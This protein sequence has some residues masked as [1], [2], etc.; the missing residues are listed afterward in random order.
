M[1]IVEMK[2]VSAI[3]MK[4][5]ARKVLASLQEAGVAEISQI[6]PKEQLSVQD[7]STEI[8]RLESE[9]Q[10]TRYAIGVIK[11]YDHSKKSFLTPRPEISASKLKEEDED[12]ATAI[13]ALMQS[14]KSIDENINAIRQKSA[15]L[16]S[17]KAQLEQFSELDVK[18]TDISESKYVTAFC[19]IAPKENLQQIKEISDELCE[20]TFMNSANELQPIFVLMHNSVAEEKRMALKELGVVDAVLEKADA[21]PAERIKQL[22]S[23]LAKLGE[24]RLAQEKVAEEEAKKLVTLMAHEVHL[25]YC[26]RRETALAKL[27]E[28]KKVNVIEGY[29]RADGTDKL[30]TALQNAAEAYYL[31]ITDPTE[32]D[33]TPTLVVNKSALTPFEAVDEMYDTPAYRGI[34]P[35]FIMAPFYFIFFGMMLSDAVYGAIIAIGSLIVLKLRQP[36]GMFRKVTMM[37]FIC[38]FSTIIWGILFGGYMGDLFGIDAAL[39]NP[40]ESALNMLILCIAV[41]IIHIMVALVMG[42]YM[43]ARKKDWMAMIFDKGMWFLIMLAIV[44]FALGSVAGISVLSTAAVVMVIVGALGLLFTQGRHKKGI[45]KKFVGGLASWYDIT[46]Y[47]SDILSYS[48]IFGM[49]LATSVIAMVFNTIAGMLTGG[50][51][52]MAIIGWIFAIVIFA[53]GHIFNMFIS[54]LGAFVH[55]M[56]LQYIESFTKFFEGGGRP[57][58][59]LDYSTRVFRIK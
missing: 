16:L 45:V 37:I 11:R 6:E 52:F 9:L 50:G 12:A 47:I 17:L 51:G 55:S 2:K 21:T 20:I 33:D 25:E 35:V 27:G 39:F 36:D 46:S 34:D 49:A 22:E 18:L 29:V 41:G 13:D 8:S 26:L 10:E 28:T 1:A 57:F 3:V 48:R 59:P 30:E 7:N 23:D 4:K 19:G 24:E 14:A 32:E 15:K 40:I 58:K 5:D 42:M 43:A 38:S 31:D 54:G 53:V 56:R 44:L